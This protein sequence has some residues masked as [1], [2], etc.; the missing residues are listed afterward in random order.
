MDLCI[1]ERVLDAV[2]DRPTDDQVGRGFVQV[3]PMLHLDA[4]W[5][6]QVWLCTSTEAVE[7]A[8][9]AYTPVLANGQAHQI[10]RGYVVHWVLA[11]LLYRHLGVSPGG[12]EWVTI[13]AHFN[14]HPEERI[15]LP[16]VATA[17]VP[18]EM[19]PLSDEFLKSRG[20]SVLE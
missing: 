4:T 16:N 5:S 7:H 14:V 8:M 2:V 10:A 6:E 20:E 11:K 19:V 13:A 12:L 3:L 1:Q 18:G 15:R 9:H 17:I